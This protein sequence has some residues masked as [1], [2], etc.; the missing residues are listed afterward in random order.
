MEGGEYERKYGINHDEL[1][2][3]KFSPSAIEDMPSDER[4]WYELLCDGDG[5][6][7]VNHFFQQFGFGRS[8]LRTEL[9]KLSHEVYNNLDVTKNSRKADSDTPLRD[10]Y[11][12]YPIIYDCLQAALARIPSNS[13]L[14]EMGHSFTRNMDTSQTPGIERNAGKCASLIAC[15]RSTSIRRRSKSSLVSR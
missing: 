7:D 15:T 10:F 2:A 12:L 11:S 13:R 5:D 4:A 14:S 9:K 6:D 1:L 3:F 8:I